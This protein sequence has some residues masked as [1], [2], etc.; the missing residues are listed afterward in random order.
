VPAASQRGAWTGQ[1]VR[2]QVLFLHLSNL[3]PEGVLGFSG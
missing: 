1:D 2:D 3:G